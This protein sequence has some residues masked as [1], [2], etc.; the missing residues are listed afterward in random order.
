MSLA[1]KSLPDHVEQLQNLVT[2]LRTELAKKDQHIHYLIEQFRLA[3]QRR[4]GKSS[5]ASPDQLELFNEAEQIMEEAE[6]AEKADGEHETITYTRTRPRRQ[7]LPESLPREQVIHDLDEADKTCDDCGHALHRMGEEK[8]EQLEFIP[9]RIKVIEHIRPKYSCRH[10]EQHGTRVNIKIAPVAPAAI[11][12]SIATPSLLSQIITSKYQYALPLYRQEALFKQ[13]GIALSRKTMADWMIKSSR[14]LQRIHQR[15][16]EILLQQSVIHADETPMKVIHADKKQSYMWVY[17]SGSDSPADDARAPPNIILYDD[18][19][20]RAGQ[21]ARDYLRDY[22]GYLQVDGYAGYQQT[23]AT[24]VGCMAHA[25][26][27]FIEAQKAQPKG[28]TGKADWAVNHIRKLYRIETALK[29][30]TVQETHDARQ[31]QSL[32]LLEQLKDWLDKSALQVPPK[33]AIGKAIAYS[34]RQWPKL[35]RYVEDGRLSI[36][37]NRAERAIK[38]F[39][40]GR[41]NWM[42]ANTQNGAHA[43]AILYSLV[44]TAKANGLTPFDYIQHLLNELP[45]QPGEIDSL[46][47]WYFKR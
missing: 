1:T 2:D 11:P 24:L 21:C 40:I 7:P 28:K 33:S 5:E 22:T 44:E 23:R 29:D 27:K 30:K 6:K 18:Q 31:R 25:R 36:D 46:L 47:P 37:N 19:N 12:K 9:A 15:L 45:K 10:C 4:F 20:S 16:H 17:C 38:P 8:S 3:Q 43:S 26:R 13:Y 32:P 41:K 42:F 34:L 14:L 39:V 35:I